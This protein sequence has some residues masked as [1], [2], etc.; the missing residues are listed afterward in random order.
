MR[1]YKADR[2]CLISLRLIVSGVSVVLIGVIRYLVSSDIIFFGGCIVIAAIALFFMLI[3]L[4]LYI[5][6][7]K[8]TATDKE[9]MRSS[10]VII[11]FHQSVMYS[12]IQY[13]TV[14]STPLAS[15]TGMNFIVFFVF[16]GQLRL[17][18]LN[19]ND[20][21]EILV[22]SGSSGAEEV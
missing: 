1:H 12:S 22:L 4:P 18:F 3:Y 6:S 15:R 5:A 11:K 8:Y 20:M 16:G 7:I 19:R 9:I 17:M 21:Q 2:S 10:G 13:T 14:I